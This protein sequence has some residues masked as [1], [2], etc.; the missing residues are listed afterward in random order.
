MIQ[1]LNHLN[2]SVA[3]LDNVASCRI[4][5]KLGFIDEATQRGIWP[6][7]GDLLAKIRTYAC[8]SEDDLP[9]LEMTTKTTGGTK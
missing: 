9:R 5:E 2:L 8:F 7:P 6:K 1:G 4:P 3:D